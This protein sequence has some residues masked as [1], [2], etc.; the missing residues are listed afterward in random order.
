MVG[1]ERHKQGSDPMLG[2]GRDVPS[3]DKCLRLCTWPNA[4]Q[5]SQSARDDGTGVFATLQHA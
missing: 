5:L 1:C 4:R 3:I 2:S